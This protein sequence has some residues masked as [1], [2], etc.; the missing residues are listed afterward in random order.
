ESLVQSAR[1]FL[2]DSLDR[3]W[4]SVVATGEAPMEQRAH[5]RLA[6][7][8]AVS[9]AVQAVDLLHLRCRCECAA[10]KLSAGAGIPRCTRNNAT[11]R[12]PSAC[13]GNN[14]P[15]FVRTGTG[16]ATPLTDASFTVRNGV[17]SIPPR[18]SLGADRTFR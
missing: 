11:H 7:S 13:H 3:L 1:L 2:F 18:S 17:V 5:V 10:H 15:R 12:G 4:S 8:H 14:R 6:A 16:Y 9:S